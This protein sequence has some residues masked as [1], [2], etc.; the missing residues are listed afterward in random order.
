MEYWIL[1]SCVGINL[2]FNL[3]LAA[4]FAAHHAG[5]KDSRQYADFEFNADHCYLFF[6][7]V[8]ALDHGRREYNFCATGITGVRI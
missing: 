7:V 1:G 2:G 8:H 6:P 4:D 5:A 3:G